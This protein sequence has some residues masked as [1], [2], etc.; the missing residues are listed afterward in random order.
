MTAGPHAPKP[1]WLKRWS[2]QSAVLLLRSPL[3]IIIGFCGI[4]A[5]ALLSFTIFSILER[6][7]NIHVAFLGSEILPISIAVLVPISICASLAISEGYGIGNKQDVI[8]SLRD[9]FGFAFKFNCVILV[10]MSAPFYWIIYA[11]DTSDAQKIISLLKSANSEM[12]RFLGEGISFVVR[13]IFASM[14]HNILWIPLITQMPMSRKEIKLTA[15]KI[16]NENTLFWLRFVFI[17]MIATLVAG[18]LPPIIGMGALIYLSAWL[19]VAARE[20]YGGISSNRKA[21]S[22]QKS[23]SAKNA[24]AVRG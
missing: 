13:V 14:L 24:S 10:F 16:S 12:N 3:T 21:S 22:E 8:H 19:Y 20:I 15:G 1:G 7:G 2:L 18:N 6:M 17:V 11:G 5:T 23:F 4:I 9:F